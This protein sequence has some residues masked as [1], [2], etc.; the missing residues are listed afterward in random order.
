VTVLHA[1][2]FPGGARD[3]ICPSSKLRRIA[4][5]LAP[6][7]AP[8]NS[9]GM[10]H[11]SYLSRDGKNLLV[12]EMEG[13]CRPCR[14][15]LF[16]GSSQGTVV[17]RPHGQCTTAAWSPDGKWMY[18]SANT[19]NRYHIWRQKLPTGSAEQVTFGATEEEGISFAPERRIVPY[20]DR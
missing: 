16:D 18:F 6:F 20:L 14:L 11:R 8:V 10:A 4:P 7:Y 9:D 19:G 3:S 2:S 15:L 5:M 12:V 17:G 13:G 1:C